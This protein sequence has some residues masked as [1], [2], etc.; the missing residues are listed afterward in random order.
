[1]HGKVAFNTLLSTSGNA[2]LT[3][4]WNCIWRISGFLGRWEE[5]YR[6]EQLL[7]LVKKGAFLSVMRAR[8]KNCE[9]RPM[10]ST[11]P[12]RDRA[13]VSCCQWQWAPGL[14]HPWWQWRVTETGCCPVGLWNKEACLGMVG[15]HGDLRLPAT[16]GES[17][18]KRITVVPIIVFQVMVDRENYN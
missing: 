3:C 12:G 14:L 7:S 4:R 2:L 16:G 10:V 5:S 13:L 9:S 18:L 8:S 11:G 17:G 6:N 1:M 15:T